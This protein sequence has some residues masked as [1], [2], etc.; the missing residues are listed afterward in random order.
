[1]PKLSELVVDFQAVYDE[2]EE[3]A[4]EC[5]PERLA[6]L[7]EL[8]LQERTKTERLI[9]HLKAVDGEIAA[10]KALEDEI[11]AKRKT[12]ERTKES[13]MGF[14]KWYMETRK[15]DKLPGEVFRFQFVKSGRPSVEVLV[16]PEQ[17]PRE[18]TKVVVTPD[19]EKIRAYLELAG[20]AA[21]PAMV[22]LGTPSV[23]VRIF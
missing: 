23:S 15:L 11:A 4:G 20:I 12:K 22:R 21:E 10:L 9:F 6:R 14:V 7:D 18:W 5:T 16:P 3:A 13:L 19:K 8:N 2:I 17:L 1:M